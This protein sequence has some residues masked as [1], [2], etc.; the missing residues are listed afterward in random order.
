[1]LMAAVSI[2]IK[3][4]YTKK[5]DYKVHQISNRDSLEIIQYSYRNWHW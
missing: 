2:Q 3:M 5:I 1:M 4:K